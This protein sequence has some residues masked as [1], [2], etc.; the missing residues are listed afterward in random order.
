MQ[1][2]AELRAKLEEGGTHYD[3]MKNNVLFDLSLRTKPEA[4]SLDFFLAFRSF[5][6]GKAVT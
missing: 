3:K 6:M 5:Y 4:P 1:N 2:F